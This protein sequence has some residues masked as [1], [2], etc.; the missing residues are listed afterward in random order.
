MTLVENRPPA[1]AQHR[2]TRRAWVALALTPLS[3]SAAV[4]ISLAASAAGPGVGGVLVGL[5]SLGAPAV[6]IALGRAAMRAKEP[7]ARKV[8]TAAAALF[9][10][11][12]VLLPVA[13]ISVGAWLVALAVSIAAVLFAGRS[14]S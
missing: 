5:L 12:A 10:V 13:V 8:V 7:G 14:V 2:Y 4:L 3:F 1:Q 6:A 9:A 11:C